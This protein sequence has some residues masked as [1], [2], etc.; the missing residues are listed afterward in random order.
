MSK[1][2]PLRY[3]ERKLLR[4]YAHCELS[5]TPQ[6]FYGKWDVNYE[7]IA[8]ICHRSLST[9]RGWFQQGEYYR[10]PNSSDLRHLAMMDFIWQEFEAIPDELWQ[11]L[12]NS[13]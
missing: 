12:C 13:D 2:K 11:K 3:R 6:A 1:Q 7:Q 10:S 5:M 9:V 4:V 8:E